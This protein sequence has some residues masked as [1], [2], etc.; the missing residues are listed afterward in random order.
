MCI[1]NLTTPILED[2][3]FYLNADS[4]KLSSLINI[5]VNGLLSDMFY[6]IKVL[7]DRNNLGKFNYFDERYLG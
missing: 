5:E 4:L 1:N 6:K 7:S 3:L 2:I